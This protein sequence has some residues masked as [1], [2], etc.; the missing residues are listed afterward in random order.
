MVFFKEQLE[1]RTNGRIKVELFFGGVIGNERELMDF[2]ATGALQSTRGGFFTDAN[3]KF[4]LLMMPFLVNDWDQAFRLVNSGFVSEIN[5]EAL[6]NY[7]RGKD[8]WSF[9]PIEKPPL[10]SVNDSSWPRTEIDHFVRATQEERDLTPVPDAS[11]IN[12]VRRAYFTLIGLPPTPGQIDAFVSDNR[13]DAFERLVDE[14]LASPHFG[15][16]W[17]RHWLDVARFAESSGGG[18]TVLFKDA[19]RYRDYIIDAFNTDMPYDVMIREQLAGDLLLFTS[20]SQHNRQL[21]ATAFLALGPTNFL[22]QNKLE[23]R[24]EV[25]DEQIDTIGKAFMGMTIGCARCHDHKFDPIP[26]ADYYR[27]TSTFTTAVRSNQPIVMNASN[28]ID[29]QARFKSEH[30]PYVDA[31]H[32]IHNASVICSATRSCKTLSG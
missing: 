11:K 15:E 8:F 21:T 5:R 9:Q 7:E 20:P 4:G 6:P 22:Q 23:Q 17:G 27:F 16:R 31:L 19:W 24:W 30:Q 25:I 14:L 13:D 28:L 32:K 1:E 18:K 26:A 10:P 29:Q 2:V 3:P 12:L